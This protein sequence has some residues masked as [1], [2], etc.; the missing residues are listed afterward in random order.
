M[1]GGED[2]PIGFIALVFS[3]PGMTN[4][5]ATLEAEALG[6]CPRGCW[7]LAPARLC[8]AGPYT[9]SA[10]VS[11]RQGAWARAPQHFATC[12]RD[13]CSLAF[14][15]GPLLFSQETHHSNRLPERESSALAE[16]TMFPVIKIIPH[17]FQSGLT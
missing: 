5:K 14:R 7:Y 3:G 15:E 13:P 6:S 8:V 12:R 11:P 10:S 17:P 2:V 1:G 4:E 16:K 9:C